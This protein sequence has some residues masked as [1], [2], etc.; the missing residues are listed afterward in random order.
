MQSSQ[1][2]IASDLVVVVPYFFTTEKE[3]LGSTPLRHF[4][5]THRPSLKR[6]ENPH[7]KA[8]RL[9]VAA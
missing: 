1:N 6:G 5:P 4:F 9:Q 7:R 3:R 8:D 2:L